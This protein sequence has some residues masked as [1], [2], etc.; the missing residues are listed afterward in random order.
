VDARY[1]RFNLLPKM[2]VIRVDQDRYMLLRGTS[3]RTA[4]AS[5]VQGFGLKK[6]EALQF[7]YQLLFLMNSVAGYEDADQFGEQLNIKNI[8]EHVS[9]A[10]TMSA[11]AGWGSPQILSD[12]N[13]SQDDLNL[14]L[15]C[16][17]TNSLESQAVFKN[18]E[19]AKSESSCMTLGY[20]HGWLTFALNG[21]NLECAEV[22][23]GNG[24]SDCIFGKKENTEGGSTVDP[25]HKTVPMEYNFGSLPTFAKYPFAMDAKVSEDDHKPSPYKK[26]E[27]SY[28]EDPEDGKR[29]QDSLYH[30][31]QRSA[32]I[33]SSLFSHLKLDPSK[34][35]IRVERER[36]VFITKTF[37]HSSLQLIVEKTFSG[38]ELSLAKSFSNKLS[39]ILGQTLGFMDTSSFLTPMLSASNSPERVLLGLPS[40]L[41]H[42]GWGRMEYVMSNC[43]FEQDDLRIHCIMENCVE[44]NEGEDKSSDCLLTCGYLQGALNQCAKAFEAQSVKKGTTSTPEK[45]AKKPRPGNLDYICV[46]IKSQSMGYSHSEFICAKS[47]CIKAEVDAACKV[48]GYDPI[49]EKNNPSLAMLAGTSPHTEPK[50]FFEKISK[51]YG[52]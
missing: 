52:Q 38:K 33:I 30:R 12:T 21:K 28:L 18:P 41:A 8:K 5:C 16:S 45:T 14:Y 7:S 1:S 35:H 47:N 15:K 49:S 3:L 48:F 29:G 25:T 6:K 36:F 42:M 50:A 24:M 31:Q 11:Y 46:Q 9:A 44:V 4:L 13:I 32:Q 39:L 19:L 10:L 43:S 40:L 22:V 2:G 51:F 23:K 27:N 26:Q 17:I 34:G 37:L 20:I